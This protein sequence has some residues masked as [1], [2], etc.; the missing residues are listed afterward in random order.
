MSESKLSQISPKYERNAFGILRVGIG[1]LL[2]T[3][4]LMKAYQ[5]ATVPTIGGGL[6]DAR[7]L[8]IFVVQFDLLFAVWL[9]A[10]L[11][12]K[13]TWVASLGCFT[14]FVLVSA[15]R[16]HVGSE[17]CGCFGAVQIFP[18][19]T[20]LL[21]LAVI[22]LLIAFRPKGIAFHRTT[23]FQELPELKRYKRVGIVAM[24][25]LLL[26]VHVTWAMMSVEKNDRAELGTKFIGANGRKTILLEPETWIGAEFPLISHFVQPNDSEI[27]KQGTWNVLLAQSDC[28]KCQE[29]KADLEA[30]KSKGIAIAMIP[31]RTNERR[32][33]TPFP[34]FMLDSQNDWFATT[35]C[36]IKLVDGV[37]VA[38][39]DS[40]IEDAKIFASVKV[41]GIQQTELLLPEKLKDD[42]ASIQTKTKIDSEKVIE[43]IKG[44]VVDEDG[45][46][47]DGV[48]V[49]IKNTLQNVII[50]ET[51]TTDLD[52]R[53][54]IEGPF[55]LDNKSK[56]WERWPRDGGMR[57]VFSKLGRELI[58]KALCFDSDCIDTDKINIV[59]RQTVQ[60]QGR[61]VD[62]QTGKG[63]PG[64]I[65]RFCSANDRN[66][67]Y[68]RTTT[69]DPDGYYQTPFGLTKGEYI[70]FVFDET[71]PKN[72]TVGKSEIVNVTLDNPV[73]RVSE[74][75]VNQ[76]G[77][78]EVFFFNEKTEEPVVLHSVLANH[79]LLEGKGHVGDYSIDQLSRLLTWGE[80]LKIRAYPG[81]N[82][83]RLGIPTDIEDEQGEIKGL[84]VGGLTKPLRVESGKTTSLVLKVAML[85]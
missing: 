75:L 80:S 7:W 58:E 6:L 30:R 57:F 34:I 47:I 67:P 29:M 70:I 26:A 23:F 43:R 27:L 68:N 72:E 82:I 39:G 1:L 85:P 10:G 79:V 17:S 84:G 71:N 9:F 49:Q 15:Y 63:V 73:C 65:V 36:V 19:Y 24:A 14:I 77:W 13:L 69:T 40:L 44:R 42:I 53:F 50:D 20:L 11:L 31:S 2:L 38:V 56:A 64:V 59:M 41:G 37:C 28:P 25:W 54:L 51:A 61:V 52:G 55:V 8:N 83:L 16:W 45:N 48:L 18:A 33:K 5:L 60:V 81:D 74:L 62:D 22:G 32:P 46:P 21:D 4:G 66:L 3:A 35:P 78:I 12:S 76:C